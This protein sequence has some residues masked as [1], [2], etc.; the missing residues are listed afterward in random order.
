MTE[1]MWMIVAPIVVFL[2]LAAIKGLGRLNQWVIGLISEA[3]VE[4]IGEK[5]EPRIEGAVA[6]AIA[7]VLAEVEVNSGSSL[8]DRVMDISRQLE[9]LLADGGR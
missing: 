6:K 1:F 5:L 8:K 9:M 2:A 7:P 4:G 3:I